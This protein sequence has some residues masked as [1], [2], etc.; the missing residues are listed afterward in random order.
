MSETTIQTAA[1][2]DFK[3]GRERDDRPKDERNDNND[4]YCCTPP[5]GGGG[6]D[7]KP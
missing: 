2:D 4:P 7:T 1:A 6:P 5:G 3:D